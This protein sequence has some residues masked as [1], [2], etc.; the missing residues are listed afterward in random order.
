MSFYLNPKRALNKNLFYK[1]KHLLIRFFVYLGFNNIEYYYVHG[2]GGGNHVY[3]D[4]GV[5]TC[6]AIFNI[7]CGDIYV[8]K[9]TLFGHGVSIITGFHSFYNGKFARFSNEAPKEVPDSGYDI[10]IGEGC[11]LGTNCIILKGVTVGDNTIIC[12]GAI[13]T[14]SVPSNSFVYGID[15]CRKIT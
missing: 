3:I 12:A 11:F 7:S 14:K 9:G 13:V 8:G 5:S 1:A 4:E 15:Q 6:N 2:E 10:K